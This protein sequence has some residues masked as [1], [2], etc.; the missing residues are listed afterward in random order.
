MPSV[1]HIRPDWRAGAGYVAAAGQKAPAAPDLAARWDKEYDIVKSEIAG[2]KRLA[3]LAPQTYRQDSLILQTDRDPT[4]VILRRTEALAADIRTLDGAPGLKALK[5]RLAQFRG[6][7][8]K[9]G[10]NDL[11]ARKAL[12][13]SVARLR[14][15][16]AF[17]NPLLDF[18]SLLLSKSHL[19]AHHCCDQYFGNTTRPGGS[20]YELS[21]PFGDKPM[22]RDILADS[23]VRNGR[24]KGQTLAGGSFRCLELSYDGRQIF[25]AATQC[26]KDRERWCPE[27]SYHVF[28]ANPDGSGLTQ[29]TDG[30]WDDFDPCLLPNG[31]VAFISERRGG[32][33]RCH[34]RP[35]PTYTLHS[36]NPDGSD[37]VTL[38]YHET[39][40]WNP[41]ARRRK[42]PQAGSAQGRPNS[43]RCSARAIT[44]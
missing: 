40:E 1:V 19:G 43:T 30:S 12:F 14:R 34:P 22:L 3:A 9:C 42:P 16:I 2:R 25:F 26:G 27:K 37:I 18:K 6:E 23:K 11:P 35:V 8:D 7:A 38:S 10:V 36:M 13:V 28:R 24:I 20:V 41:S 44:T 29:L 33:G 17:S 21:D 32:F 5:A 31:R 39:N 15:R 4:D